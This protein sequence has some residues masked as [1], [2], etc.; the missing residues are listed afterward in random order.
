MA[1]EFR[2]VAQSDTD[3]ILKRDYV[4]KDETRGP[5][6]QDYDAT[7]VVSIIGTDES[8]DSYNTKLRV[9]GWDFTNFRKNPA[10]LWAHN[11]D[12]AVSMMPLGRIIGIQREEFER[13]EKPGAVDKR[14]AFE[15]E[16]PKRGT[17][18]FADL[19]CD[20]YKQGHL[21]A[22][23]VGF[24]NLKMR[25]LDLKDDKEELERDG[26]DMK[27][28]FAADLTHNA[29]IE[30]S[31]V[32]VGS[33][34]NALVKALRDGAPAEVRGLLDHAPESGMEID[35]EWIASRL[36]A[37]R[38]AL[39]PIDPTKP[40]IAATVVAPDASTKV[41]TVSDATQGG[42]DA[43]ERELEKALADSVKEPVAAHVA[44]AEFRSLIESTNLAMREEMKQLRETIVALAAEIKSTRS[45]APGGVHATPAPVEPALDHLDVILAENVEQLE[46][47]STIFP[48]KKK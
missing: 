17:Y 33:N 45:A 19:A 23:S 4:W 18:P 16:F 8:V 2:V 37:L 20:M 40:V 22:S 9:D 13:A 10:F 28:G 26:Y 43:F 7:R 42:D 36:E 34:P 15:V 38:L 32:P 35:D 29:L 11:S 5:G 30:L 44:D 14:L 25:R 47:L 46:R 27:K 21:R 3:K 31:A 6:S 24:K 39:A 1:V 41:P 12:P 48:P